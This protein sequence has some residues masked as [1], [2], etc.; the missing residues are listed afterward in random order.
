MAPYSREC[1]ELQIQFVQ[2][3]GRALGR[4]AAE[5]L[6]DYTMLRR[7]LSADRLE[8]DDPRWQ[9]FV[10]GFAAAA[11]PLDWTFRFYLQHRPP[12]PADGATTYRGSTLF[13]PFT[14]DT[15]PRWVVG[16]HVIIRPHFHTRVPIAGTLLGRAAQPARMADLRALFMDVRHHFPDAERGRGDS[17]LYNLDAYRRLFP[18]EYTTSMEESPHGHFTDMSRWG[19]FFDREWRINAPLAQTLISRVDGLRDPASL[20]GCFPY[21]VLSPHCDIRFC[22]SFYGIGDR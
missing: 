11:D 12:E 19:Q 1:F 3:L 13:G 15:W 14:Y 17:W 2:C 4:G 8:A 6:A 16:D 7:V 22:Y 18:P 5:F 21:P 10:A 20:S 9:A